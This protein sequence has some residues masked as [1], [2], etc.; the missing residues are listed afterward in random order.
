LSGE[1]QE[2]KTL[3]EILRRRAGESPE[4]TAL[5]FPGG[6]TVSYGRLWTSALAWAGFLLRSGLEEGGRVLIAC[7]N[8]P[9]FFYLFYAAQLA[10]GTAV[11]VFPGSGAERIHRFARL[12]DASHLCISER[13][14]PKKISR[15]KS[16]ARGEGRRLLVIKEPPPEVTKTAFSEIP[17]QRTALIQFTSGSLGEPKGV[18]ISHHSLTANIR[19][20]IRGFAITERDRF[21]SWLPVFHDMGLILM[22]LVPLFLGTKVFQLPS[23]IHYLGSWLKAI[24]REKGTFTAAPDFAYRMCLVLIPDPDHYDLSSLRVA[25][26]AAE[27]VRL[28]TIRRFEKAFRLRNVLCPAYGLAEATVG[29]AGWEP[30]RPIRTDGRGLVSVGRPFSGVECR[31]AEEPRPKGPGTMETYGEIRLKSPASTSGYFRNPAATDDLF[32][33]EGFLKTGDLG[34]LDK[35]G[36]LY[37]AGRK[38]NVI[39]HGG[40]TISSREIEEWADDLPLVRRSAALGIDR[41]GPAGEQ[42]FLF[43]ESRIPRGPGKDAEAAGNSLREI[44]SRFQDAFGFRPGRVTLLKPRS[45][46]MTSNGKIRYDELRRL[47]VSGELKKMGLIL[48][49]D[50]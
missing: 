9:E 11:P 22:T 28:S 31:I 6:P 48:F 38:K 12:S 1:P 17:P 41:G 13:I 39:I 50:F 7:P 42:V 19:Q 45:I 18:M 27:P 35:K 21:V 8:S 20:M 30:G 25:L 26:N 33:A 2:G 15:L 23:S 36:L 10:G 37:V 14:S 5:Q 44:V 49:P 46:P 29:V 47:H 43:L 32:D 40:F 34:Y 24:E 16:L 4:K 3:P